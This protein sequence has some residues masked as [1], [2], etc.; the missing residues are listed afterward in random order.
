VGYRPRL[1]HPRLR[2]EAIKIGVV[3]ELNEIA[4]KVD[5][6]IREVLELE[7]QPRTLYEASR[8][9]ID[10][11][12]KRL[13]PFL[14]IKSCECVGGASEDAIRVAAAVEVLHNFT[15]VHDDIMDQDEK[16]RGSP[17][18]HVKWGIPIAI[19]A[20]DLLFAKVYKLI[21]LQA[22][23][24][25]AFRARALRVIETLTDA[26]IAICEGQAMDLIFEE[27]T[28]VSEDDYMKMIDG[29]T[30]ALFEASARCGAIVGG[31]RAG[32]VRRLGNFGRYGG[33]AFQMIDD[34]LG[35]VGDEKTLGKPVGSDLREGK[36]TLIMI[37][38]LSHATP[39]QAKRIRSVLG[40]RRAAPD[41]VMSVT[42]LVGSL[43]SIDYV[44]STAETYAERAKRE[45][46][47]FTSS[48]AR[49]SLMN[50]VD[51]FVS[52]VY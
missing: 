46:R 39:E 47:S 45:L 3:E 25:P 30:A 21:L 31:G 22:R 36:R 18:V 4:T 13:R 23:T 2:K 33:L 28:D 10:A 32:Q 41:E 34:V 51:F 37:H 42:K 35:V 27:K 12:G 15:L 49:E 16:R 8:H 48:P 14:V 17:T 24:P 38:A 5:P 7:R 26:T 40:N 1:R 52:R 11:G 44:R 29:K 9:L 20:G 43:G 19:A 6:A 50:L